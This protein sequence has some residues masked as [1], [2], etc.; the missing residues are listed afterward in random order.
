MNG[1]AWGL[2][3]G[4][5]LD[6]RVNGA[7]R[8]LDDP[9]IMYPR[10]ADLPGETAALAV[11]AACPVV[12]ACRRWALDPRR[13]ERH[14]VWGGLTEQQRADQLAPIRRLCSECDV[15]FTPDP[16]QPRQHRCAVC[17][18]KTRQHQAML[19]FRSKAG[20]RHA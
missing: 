1:S 5:R 14:G 12:D 11:C 7:C 18:R 10:C 19:N 6:W 20:A 8:Q 13:P 17:A 3:S 4:G 2:E 9:D 15:R 16:R